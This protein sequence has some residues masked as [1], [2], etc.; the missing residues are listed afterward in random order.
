MY[1]RRVMTHGASGDIA[2]ACLLAIPTVLHKYVVRSPAAKAYIVGQ[3][4]GGSAEV[5]AMPLADCA[6]CDEIVE[7]R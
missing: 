4:L 2:V 3:A 5:R 7:K 1:S 6:I